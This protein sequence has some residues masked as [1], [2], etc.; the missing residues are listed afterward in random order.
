M[1][2]TLYIALSRQLATTRQMDLIANNLANADT[3]GFKGEQMMFSEHLA[4]A[5]GGDS[6]SFVQDRALAR[7]LRDG[8][9]ERTGA[10]LDLAIRGKGWFVIE[11]KNGERYTRDGHFKID[12]EGRLVTGAGDS[13]LGSNG[14]PIVFGRDDKDITIHEDGTVQAEGTPRGKLRIVSFANEH[15]LRNVGGNLFRGSGA[16]QDV[17]V[18]RIS[19]GMIETSNVQPVVQMTEMIKALRTFQGTQQMIENEHDRQRALI[20]KLTNEN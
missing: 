17:D 18:P 4:R 9:L 2:N 8:K 1:E 5:I 19:Q 11:T 6:M 12:G 15:E 3:A 20:D 14:T 16:P 7:D 10:P 13:V